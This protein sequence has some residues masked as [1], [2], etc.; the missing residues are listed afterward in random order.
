MKTGLQLI[1]SA[2]A[3]KH[4]MLAAAD[5]FVLHMLRMERKARSIFTATVAVCERSMIRDEF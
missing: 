2:L 3:F 5:F 4:T 1:I